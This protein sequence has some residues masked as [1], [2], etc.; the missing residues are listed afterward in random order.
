ML[1][2]KT[3]IALFPK[4]FRERVKRNHKLT[5]FYRQSLHKSGL[6]I[7]AP[8]V[9][10]QRSQYRKFLPWQMAQLSAIDASSFPLLAIYVV[11][12]EEKRKITL[13]SV[14]EQN[15]HVLTVLEDVNLWQNVPDDGY[16]LMLQAG[17]TLCKGA[18]ACFRASQRS[19]D[20][21]Y[22]DTD[23]VQ[24]KHAPQS[25]RFL[26]DWNPDL[27]LSTAYVRTGVMIRKSLLVNL[28][29]P[30][31][32]IADI[33]TQVY[34]NGGKVAHIPFTLVHHPHLSESDD[35][36]TVASRAQTLCSVREVATVSQL[37][38]NHLQWP[39]SHHPLVSLIIPTRNAWQLVK[40]CIDSIVER[41]VYT[42]YEI[43][44]ID[45]DSDDPQSLAYFSEL[46]KQPNI[47]VLQYP[48]EFN[49]SA[50]NNFA[51]TQAR[52]EVIGLINN[53]I[54]VIT[55]EWLTLMVG[56]A[57]R[58]DIGCVGAKLL[59]PDGRVQHAGVVLGYGGGAGHAHKY[60]PRHHP[61]YLYRLA[62]TQNYSAVT[63]ACLLVKRSLYE[64]VGGLNEKDLTVAFND[65]DFCLRVAEQG[66]RNLYCAE[67][68][69]YHHESVSRGFDIA[70]EKA[71]R[72]AK[73]VAY[74]QE[75]WAHVIQHDPAYSP[76]LTLKRENFAI[77]ERT[78]R[79][80]SHN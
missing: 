65:V 9:R 50:I 16:I 42:R 64:A 75:R 59:Y 43:L 28:P 34:F 29:A 58:P 51:V 55:P 17:D 52:G 1:G 60:F 7:G 15:E 62:A 8:S 41:T 70:P 49:Y 56:H 76:N 46:A 4:A 10:Q 27:Q 73:E 6:F 20:V 57:L 63:A 14:V 80:W 54:E 12:D 24:G 30:S 79:H 47:R 53:D 33:M 25:P 72:F 69:L 38:I 78:E 45:N 5:E 21:C 68:E 71:A 18:L 13:S 66:V 32:P 40:A 37:P 67:A 61:G 39:V 31:A 22:S 48:G 3:A 26:P 77:R 44:L 35:H 19:A 23:E 11:G 74:L 36:S 2:V